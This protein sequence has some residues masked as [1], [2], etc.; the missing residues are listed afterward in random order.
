MILNYCTS[1][2]FFSQTLGRMNRLRSGFPDGGG[3]DN[4][5][6]YSSLG[7]EEEQDRAKRADQNNNNSSS[8]ING[9]KAKVG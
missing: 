1:L 4:D 8:D 2:L 3:S 9:G 5:D 6:H 7:Y